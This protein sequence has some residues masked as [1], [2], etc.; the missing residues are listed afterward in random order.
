MLLRNDLGFGYLDS[1]IGIAEKESPI[2]KVGKDA[3]DLVKIYSNLTA[4]LTD[5]QK[6]L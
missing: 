5:D 2:I 4:G 6:K 1:I 3:E